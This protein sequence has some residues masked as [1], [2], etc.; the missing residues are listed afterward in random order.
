MG[1]RTSMT[2]L[3]LT[4]AVAL[5]GCGDEDTPDRSD[6]P[7]SAT[8]TVQLAPDDA[9]CSGW[10]DLVVLQG[11]YVAGPTPDIEAMLLAAVDELQR[12][13]APE[14][15]DP[16]G[17]TEMTAV[18]DDVRASV[19]PSF[20]PSVA[21]SEPADVGLGHDHDHGDEDEAEEEHVEAPF[22][23]WLADHCAP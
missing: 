9:W 23:T 7:T 2:V 20:T 10:Q 8:P 19:D 5:A 18:L 16:A 3:A 13:G 14:S 22:G 6:D 12:L 17:Y 21:P 4:A 15:L 11:Q 1:L